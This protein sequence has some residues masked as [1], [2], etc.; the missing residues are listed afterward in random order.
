MQKS[1]NESGVALLLTII[2]LL[3]F[4]AFAI[5]SL[6]RVQDDSVNSG[7]SRS[8]V[9]NISAASAGVNIALAQL[10]S[11]AGG[12]SVN[13]API[14]IPDLTLTGAGQGTSIRSGVLG[15]STPQP[16]QFVKF[17]ADPTGGGQLNMGS[18]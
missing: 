8:Y 11:S 5:S 9:M 7:A 15:N 18:G 12:L 4:S 17:V 10:K 13:T 3:L 16:I 1:T 2:M 14:N 6:N